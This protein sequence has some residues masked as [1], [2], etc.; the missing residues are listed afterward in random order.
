M[1]I[2]NQPIFEPVIGQNDDVEDNSSEKRSNISSKINRVIKGVVLGAGLLSGEAIVNKVEAQTPTKIES[3]QVK[4]ETASAFNRL[5]IAIKNSSETGFVFDEM[6]KSIIQGKNITVL[7]SETS[8]EKA[9]KIIK[10]LQDG[11]MHVSY[12]IG[13][14]NVNRATINYQRHDLNMAEIIRWACTDY[15]DH[16]N[17]DSHRDGSVPF[18]LIVK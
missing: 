13:E 9:A 8:I 6:E 11:G 3:S 18:E 17:L 15:I 14:S 5:E 10:R 12:S 16:V 2:E 7:V 4:Q 1:S